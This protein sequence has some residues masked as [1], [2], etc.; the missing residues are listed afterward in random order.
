VPPYASRSDQTPRDDA[1]QVQYLV[2]LYE[3]YHVNVV[4]T[5][6][7]HYY[8]RMKPLLGGQVTTLENGGVVY[9]I[10]GGGGAGLA[11]V[12]TGAL[13]PR[14]DVKVQAYHLTM[15]EINDCRLQ[16][17]ARHKDNLSN[18]Q[19]NTFDPYTIDRCGGTPPPAPTANFTATPTSGTA[20]LSVQFS[21]TSTGSPTA[22]QWD[23]DNNG[24]VD[25][26]AQ[27]PSFSYAN[28]GTYSVKLTVSNAGGSNSITKS[29]FITVSSGGGGSTLTFAPS[30]DAYV[31]SDSATSSFGTATGLRV[32]TASSSQLRSYLTFDVSGLTGA[33][34]SAKLRLYVADA[35]TG[36]GSAYRSASTSWL[37]S[38]T[39]ALTWNNQ[40][41]LSGNPLSTV[42]AATLNSWVEFDLG[43]SITTNGSYSFALS[44]GTS[45]VVYYNSREASANKPQLVL[46][47]STTPVAPTASFSATPTSGTA[48]L[49]VQFTDT[50]TGSPSAGQ[51][52]FDNNGTVDS[53]AQNP[54]VTYNTAGSYAVKL[55]VS[56]A[57]GADTL[58]TSAYITVSNTPPPAPTASFSATPTSGT[59]PLSVQFTDTST[60][61][62]SAWQWD[63]DNNG[64]V[65]S[66]AQNPSVTYTAAGS[67]SVKL[68][69]SNAQGATS[70]T[71]SSFITVSSGGG[72]GGTSSATLLP[73]G[74]VARDATIKDQAGAT[75]NLYAA[76]DDGLST[77]DDGTTYVRNDNKTSGSYL[78]QLNDLPAN[79]ATMSNLRIGIRART[80]GWV[81]DTTVLYAQV[82]AADGVTPL[83]SEVAVATNPGTSA[84]V[85]VANVA[86]GG[87]VGG[88]KA[89]WDGAQ[90]RLRWGYTAVG[91]AD[92]T[93]VRLSAVALSADFTTSP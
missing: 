89:Q 28:A 42:G 36:G 52:D 24:T 66:T 87:V 45:D 5:G 25:S 8:E 17:Y 58:T 15:F 71:K 43:S 40:P 53:T 86:F 20:P 78:A 41:G 57:Q 92:S 29:A 50:S 19:L 93:Q 55:T 27:N 74:D 91:T 37:E 31:K 79:F 1:K 51:W 6:H 68:T 30:A 82:L 56:N 67:Y 7:W 60:G 22:W 39:G 21:D 11:G 44:G 84:W 32:K 59:A 62:P 80:T 72:G 12:G 69:V 77:P 33:V 48:P 46:T 38:G 64:T 75:S 10:T 16:L 61:S 18:G 76:L 34:T 90:V 88:D 26:T 47:Q 83:T 81:D 70:L 14:T 49:S 4:L 2:P 65:D 54:S 3:K 85:T 13:N 35:S 23:F 9:L 63:F 73:N